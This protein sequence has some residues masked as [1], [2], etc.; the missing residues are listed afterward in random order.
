MTTGMIFVAIE[1]GIDF[2]DVDENVIEE[3]VFA[4]QADRDAFM[5]LPDGEF[6]A[7]FPDNP[8]AETAV[9]WERKRYRAPIYGI[10]YGPG[11][12]QAR[13]GGGYV[14]RGAYQFGG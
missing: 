11:S 6:Y 4:N 8:A 2:V 12:V 1:Y 13:F 7:Q 5:G 9:P 3:R 10:D 14:P